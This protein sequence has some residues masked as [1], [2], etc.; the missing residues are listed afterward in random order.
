MPISKHTL[1]PLAILLS[2]TSALAQSGP[3]KVSETH[4]QVV[5]RSQS[6]ERTAK[7]GAPVRAGEQVVTGVSSNATI[8]RG[9]EFVTLRPNTQVTIVP[10]ERESGVVQ[11]IQNIGSAIFNIGRQPNPHFGVDT[12]YLAAVVKGT[13]FSITVSGEGA[14]MQVTEGAVE[15]ATVDGGARDLIRPGEVAIIAAEDR[16]RLTVEGDLSRHFDSPQRD[17]NVSASGAPAAVPPL[18]PVQQASLVTLEGPT[19]INGAAMQEA[20]IV[21]A[22]RSSPADLGE[23][24]NGLV[25]GE[26]EAPVLEAVFE[27]AV[28][29]DEDLDEVTVGGGDAGS[30]DD[31]G[32]NDAGSDGDDA[33]SDGDDGGDDD[34][35]DDDGSDD[36]G[37]DDDDGELDEDE[38]EDDDRAA[39]VGIS[40]L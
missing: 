4:G 24:T 2:S 23:I 31:D 38:G 13:T 28:V 32:G 17:G 26:L 15:A 20:V 21:T 34:G 33:G 35:G 1:V 6:G 11:I 36:D 22:V 40:L 19:A 39:S 27:E 25:G 30:D 9:N 16:Y 37:G 18:A 8:V 10:R 3:W 12:P 5:I 7:R 14:S 29:E